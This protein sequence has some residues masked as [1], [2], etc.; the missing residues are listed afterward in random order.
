M[1][2]LGE[3]DKQWYASLGDSRWYHI[4]SCCLALA[5]EIAAMLCTRKRSAM[6]FGKVVF[7]SVMQ[8]LILSVFCGGRGEGRQGVRGG[9][10]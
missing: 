3:L 10:G 5:K 4:V 7:C 2:Q 8:S 1:T 6:I 9:R